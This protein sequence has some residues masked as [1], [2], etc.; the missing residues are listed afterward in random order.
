MSSPNVIGRVYEITKD[1]NR[2]YSFKFISGNRRINRDNV[3]KLK[4]SFTEH[5]WIGEPI[6]VDD[7]FYIVS[8]QHRYTA[9]KELGIPIRYMITHDDVSVK[10]IQ[11]TSQA[12]RKWTKLDI[13]RS[14]ADEGNINYRNM[15]TLYEQFV[16]TRKVLPLNALIA[17]I[18]RQYET[19]SFDK[20]TLDGGL[21][22]NI[23][24]MNK[25]ILT[26]SCIEECV[27][28]I[29]SNQKVGRFDYICKA[30][31]FMLDNGAD[32]KRLKSKIDTYFRDVHSVSNTMQALEIL[33]DIYN[34]RCSN[35]E[36]FVSKYKEHQ[37]TRK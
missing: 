35:K 6:V 31:L 32:A 26:L 33:E 14:Y 18:T 1:N 3:N 10:A 9:A 28:P 17:V 21:Q 19:T 5:G 13:I 27:L 25:H 37:E 29:K 8:G 30:V 11:D 20:V 16:T 22:L 15:I 23:D 2:Y 36:Y 12:V 34:K 7:K 4:R 24:D